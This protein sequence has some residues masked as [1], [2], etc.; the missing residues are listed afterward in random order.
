[1]E[2][3]ADLEDILKLDIKSHRT[4]ILFCYNVNDAQ[5]FEELD[6]WFRVADR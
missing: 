1:M 5:S 4:G 6:F 2:C 3:P